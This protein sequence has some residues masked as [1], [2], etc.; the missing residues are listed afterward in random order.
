[1]CGAHIQ[2]LVSFLVLFENISHILHF[3]VALQSIIGDYLL[4]DLK[5]GFFLDFGIVNL[6][7]IPLDL[8]LC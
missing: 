8:V 3:F 6:F 7:E 2:L 5:E 1:M 4:S